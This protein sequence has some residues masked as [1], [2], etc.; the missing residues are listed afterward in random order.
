MARSSRLIAGGAVLALLSASLFAYC[1]RAGEKP[2]PFP[3]VEILYNT[4]ESHRAIAEA[5][6]QMWKDE[7]HVNVGLANTEWKVYLDKMRDLDYQIARAGWVFDYNDPHNIFECWQTGNGNNRTGWSNKKYDELIEKATLVRDNAERWKVYQDAERLAVDEAPILPIYIYVNK[8]MLSQKVKGWYDNVLNTHPYDAIWIEEDGKVAPPDRQKLNF[9]NGAEPQT[10]DPA[11]MS[12]VPESRIAIALYEGL[13]RYD[14]KDLHPIP[15]VAE[16][17]EISEDGKTY[18][19][20]LRP[21]ARWSNGDPVTASDFVYSWL[22]V[23]DPTQLP[24]P[25]EYAQVFDWIEGAKPVIHGD[26]KTCDPTRIGLDARDARTLVVRLAAPCPFFLNLCAHSTY[27]PVHRAT[28]E[29]HGQKWTRPENIVGN[30]PFILKQWELSA[31]IVFGPSP[32]YWGHERVKLHEI[33]FFPIDSQDTALNKF[34][35]GECDWLDD[36]PIARADEVKKNPCFRA[37]PFLTIYFYR[38]NCTKPPFDDPRV[39]RAFSMAVDKKT[40]CSKVERF[41]EIPLKGVCPPCGNP[42]YKGVPGLPY[43]PEGAR[44]LLREAGYEVP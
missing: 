29:R 41:G 31:K 16:S 1:A 37:S 39:R 28:V 27:Y 20:H 17:W 33:T 18:T 26:V 8:N 32:T 38:F 43:D 34:L 25:A 15:G 13:T 7:L 14:P 10:L 24:Q 12:G 11:I 36:V 23:I 40:I 44:K 2:K 9:N 19:F 22:R 3:K 4:L 6:A 30:G 21:D 5:L 42:P 35:A